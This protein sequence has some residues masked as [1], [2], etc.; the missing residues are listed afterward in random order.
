M[1]ILRTSC[2]LFV[3]LSSFYTSEADKLPHTHQPQPFS[4]KNAEVLQDSETNR[5]N[6]YLP[7]IAKSLSPCSVN[8]ETVTET[9]TVVNSVDSAQYVYPQIY[10]DEIV[11]KTTT[12]R[13]TITETAV[14]TQ[15]SSDIKYVPSLI[16]RTVGVTHTVDIKRADITSTSTHINTITET[17]IAFKTLVHTEYRPTT[18]YKT[19]ISTATQTVISQLR[20]TSTVKVT[21][22]QATFTQTDEFISYT[23]AYV[24]VQ[25]FTRT[26]IVYYPIPP[27]QVKTY[28]LPDLLVTTV[29]T[30]IQTETSSLISTVQQTTTEVST[31][32][33]RRPSTVY[34]T[35][36][37]TE[38]N[39]VTS[40]TVHHVKITMTMEGE[41]TNT[42][43]TTVYKTIVVAITA[44]PEPVVVTSTQI[45]RPYD[46][47][48][49]NAK[50]VTKTLT[51]YIQ[52]TCQ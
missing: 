18:L 15:V 29:S 17:E 32:K 8:T 10:V 7:P 20:S 22:P 48:A 50:R 52:K 28:Q 44:T 39:I 33:Y 3:L 5:I 4:G 1:D 21:Q 2:M 11:T 30:T 42:A 24:T 47:Q 27:T 41:I 23:P 46:I 36:E 43:T 35:T 14:T 6:G 51:N 9:T 19:E 12:A 40:T 38:K 34:V 45:V 13:K 37:V 26:S 49:K 25:P 16:F 31:L